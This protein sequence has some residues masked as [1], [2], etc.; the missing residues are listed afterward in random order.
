MKSTWLQQM[1]TACLLAT[2]S[3]GLL[4]QES[5]GRNNHNKVETTPQTNTTTQVA[6]GNVVTIDLNQPQ[7]TT[8]QTTLIVID[9]NKVTTTGPQNNTNQQTPPPITVQNT[10]GSSAVQSLNLKGWA[11]CGGVDAKSK[12]QGNCGY[13]RAQLIGKARGDCP[14]GT[15]FD[16]GTW[17]CY[18]CPSGYN[19]TGNNVTMWDACSK[20]VPDELSR[21]KYESKVKSAP[22]APQ[23]AGAIL[24]GRNGGE[25]WSC[26]EGYGRT[27]AAVNEW[28]ACGMILKDAK[29]ATFLAKACTNGWYD[30]RNGGEC[31]S[32]PAGFNRSGAAVNEW[33]ACVRIEDLK[34]SEKIAAL[35]CEAGDHFDTI[36]GGTC[37]RCPKGTS[38]SL[39]HVK[40]SE[41][42][43]ITEMRWVAPPRSLPGIFGL[44]GAEELAIEMMK[45]RAI[46]DGTLSAIARKFKGDAKKMIADEWQTLATKP[47]DSAV[48]KGL[49]FARVVEIAKMPAAKRTATEAKYLAAV[50]TAVRQNKLFLAEQAQQYY[51]MWVLKRQLEIAALPPSS[52]TYGRLGTPP[53]ATSV[54]FDIIGGTAPL[55]ML[56][57]V[58]YG[59]VMMATNTSYPALLAFVPHAPALTGAAIDVATSAATTGITSAGSSLSSVVAA[60]APVVAMAVFAVVATTQVIKEAIDADRVRITTQ[61]NVEVAKQPVNINTLLQMKDGMEQLSYHWATITNA[62]SAS[63]AAFTNKI[64]AIQTQTTA[65]GLTTFDIISIA[66]N[67]CL[68]ADGAKVSLVACNRAKPTRWVAK[69]GSLALGSDESKCLTA[70]ATPS[71]VTCQPTNPQ[72]MAQQKWSLDQSGMIVS[73]AGSCLIAKGNEVMVAGCNPTL[74]GIK[75]KAETK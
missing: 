18:K 2:L 47:G 24:D 46:V 16:I 38:R 69:R 39:A 33:N 11:R 4:A 45:D 61:N 71:L 70:A 58:S 51:D 25:Y 10:G 34:P 53:E 64:A 17:A 21:A 56:G 19:R 52:R 26:P 31:W 29:P 50:E 48:L 1:G 49:M 27:A 7:T 9:P 75:W 5:T 59:F 22:S 37:W 65:S 67:T 32:C 54:V 6:P 8:P 66:S 63:S 72:F 62:A 35:T 3:T 73:G 14:S 20:K 13:E 12:L 68:Q 57:V 23:P 44:A 74:P 42:C 30:P 55:G 15:I 60:S 43:H 36:D 41:A 40:G 28:N